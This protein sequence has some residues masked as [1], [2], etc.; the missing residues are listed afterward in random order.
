MEV[1]VERAER[2]VNAC[3]DAGVTLMIAYHVQAE[4]AVRRLRE[5][6]EG[7][8]IGTLVQLHGQF[9]LHLFGDDDETDVWRVDP[10]VAG[11]GAL[12]DVRWIQR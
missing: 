3:E 5:L 8:F 7:G 10:A 1:S 12:S 2:I 9:S 4:P 6:I 11:G